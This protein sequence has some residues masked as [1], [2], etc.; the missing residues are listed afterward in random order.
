[1][2]FWDKMA[3]G[4]SSPSHQTIDMNTGLLSHYLPKL[5]E[6]EKKLVLGGTTLKKG[7][8]KVKVKS[9]HRVWLFVTPRTVAY[10]AS[11]SM[12]F[13]RQ[14]YWSGMPL[15][16]PGIFLTQGSNLG[17]HIVGRCFFWDRE[18]RQIPKQIHSFIN[19]AYEKH[20]HKKNSRFEKS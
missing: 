7:K 8:V 5:W 4:V 16:L 3:W 10:Q 11:L 9:L 13:S 20:F 17:P 2:H 14:E 18:E 1:M 6:K 19:I 12:G 15:L